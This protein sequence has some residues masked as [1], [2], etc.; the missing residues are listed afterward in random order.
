M[1]NPAKIKN[2]TEKTY[3][4]SSGPGGQHANKT[5]TKVQLEFDINKS[6]LS[7]DEKKL[8]LEK[9]PNGEIHVYNQESRSQHQNEEAAFEHLQDLIEENLE[10]PAERRRKKAP[11]LTRKGKFRRMLK[12]KLLKYKARY[13]GR[14]E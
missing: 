9:F 12:N 2:A 11:H 6:E 1:I 3:S 13:L 14:G 4:H 5:S 7:E 10:V 8:L